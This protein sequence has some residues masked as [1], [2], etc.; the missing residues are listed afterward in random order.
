M[1]EPGTNALDLTCAECGRSPRAGET[2]RICSPTSARPWRTARS[3][4]GARVR[5]RVPVPMTVAELE[6]RM[7]ELEAV[8]GVRL[9]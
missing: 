8:Q 3:V 4:R 6:A 1:P 7:H 2:W 5:R 9:T